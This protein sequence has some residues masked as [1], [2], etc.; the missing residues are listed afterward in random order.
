VIEKGWLSGV[1]SV[2]RNKFFDRDVIVK[3]GFDFF[4]KIPAILLSLFIIV[5]RSIEV[6]V[7]NSLPTRL[8]SLVWC[9]S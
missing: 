4:G 7:I 8:I 3:I 9:I 6:G 5:V 1:G 2:I